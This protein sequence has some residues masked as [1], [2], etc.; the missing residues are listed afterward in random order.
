A[1]N[2]V[3]AMAMT[4]TTTMTVAA[5]AT[6]GNDPVG[7]DIDPGGQ[8]AEPAQTRLGRQC[9]VVAAVGRVVAVPCGD[10]ETEQMA[11]LGRCV[12]SGGLDGPHG[13]RR[14]VSDIRGRARPGRWIV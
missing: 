5:T 10:E 14:L 11:Q 12:P 4:T 13:D 6:A 2:K 3:P 7:G 9:V 8:R 1:V